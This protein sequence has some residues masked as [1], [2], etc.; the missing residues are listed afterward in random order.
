MSEK[1]W[2]VSANCIELIH[3]ATSWGHPP[4]PRKL[5]LF[6][7]FL[8]RHVWHLFRDPCQHQA[9]RAAELFADGEMSD[10]NRKCYAAAAQSYARS[11]RSLLQ[12]IPAHCAT[13]SVDLYTITTVLG[14]IT[15]TQDRW[16]R[17]GWP[18]PF[19]AGLG[20][21]VRPLSPAIMAEL[22]RD[23][24]RCPYPGPT[25]PLNPAWR[26][27][28]VLRMADAAYRHGNLDG[29]LDGTALAVVAD[30]LEEAG[31]NDVLLLTRLR[32]AGHRPRARGMWALDLVLGKE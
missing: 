2:F 19:P 9:I 17:E 10:R 14:A 12:R 32:G 29:S 21:T 8:A 30:A 11:T 27:P 26:T 18:G 3:L 28:D 6:A 23:F 4:S 13:P 22:L 1:K 5:R 15:V 16:S 7:C 20:Q 25:R 24:L 31:C